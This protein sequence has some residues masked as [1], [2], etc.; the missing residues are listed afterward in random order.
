[1]DPCFRRGDIVS[2]S[3]PQQELVNL[4]NR[5]V[6]FKE[7]VISYIVYSMSYFVFCVKI[8][9]RVR[10]TADKLQVHKV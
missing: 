7:K 4:H 9:L 1:M 2:F 5:Q 10:L 6:I 3:F 8:F